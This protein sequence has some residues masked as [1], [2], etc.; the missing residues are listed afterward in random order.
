VDVGTDTEA[1]A[2]V[3]RTCGTREFTDEEAAKV[4]AEFEALAPW[5]QFQ[6]DWRHHRQRVLAR[7]QQGHGR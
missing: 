1:A 2:P 6:R 7:H 5:T 3:V 4:E